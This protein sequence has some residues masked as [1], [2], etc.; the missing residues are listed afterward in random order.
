MSQ[1]AVQQPTAKPSYRPLYV[2]RLPVGVW[3]RV[4]INA[5]RSGLRLSAYL[6]KLL[7]ECEPLDPATTG[8]DAT[9]PTSIPSNPL[10]SHS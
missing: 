3:D 10:P 8:S 5:I 1:N 7:E 6:V 9:S 2:R 4:H